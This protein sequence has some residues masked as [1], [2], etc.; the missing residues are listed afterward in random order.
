GTLNEHALRGYKL[1]TDTKTTNCLGCHNGPNFTDDQF[2]NNGASKTLKNNGRADRTGFS[3]DIG[4][5]ACAV[6]TT[7]VLQGLRCAVVV[8]LV[9]G[10]VRAIMAA[11]A[12]RR[13]GVR[14]ELI[15]T[16][17][18]L[19]ERSFAL[20]ELIERAGIAHERTLERCD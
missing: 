3:S 15:A 2:H 11:E 12:I 20:V 14:E 10:E 13:L 8:E 6:C 18:M 17:S 9:V 7:V 19:V 16:Q 4:A 1:F 5:E